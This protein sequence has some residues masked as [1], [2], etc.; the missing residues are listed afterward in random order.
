MNLEMQESIIVRRAAA[1]SVSRNRRRGDYNGASQFLRIRMVAQSQRDCVLQPK[2]APIGRGYLG[3]LF[4]NGCN[5]N[6]V[7]AKIPGAPERNG[8]N[9]VA[10]E[11]VYGP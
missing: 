11:F 6:G 10:V 4:G 7:A 5:A 8:R 2:V 3:C 9:R 1:R